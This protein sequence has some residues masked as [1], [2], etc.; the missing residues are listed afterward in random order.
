MS[1]VWQIVLQSF[2]SCYK[3][4]DGGPERLRDQPR[5]PHTFSVKSQIGTDLGFAGHTVSVTYS[6]F[7]SFVPF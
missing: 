2:P 4:A 3:Q 1:E 6:F 5:G 7:L